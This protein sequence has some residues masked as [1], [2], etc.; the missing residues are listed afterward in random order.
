MK[1]FDLTLKRAKIEKKK[2][3]D[4]IATTPF[5]ISAY[6]DF[7]R[8]CADLRI[9]PTI[10]LFKEYMATKLKG[11][12]VGI[13]ISAREALQYRDSIKEGT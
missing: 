9:D 6:D 5:S 8:A 12:S 11:A 7:I 2:Y 3:M 4:V 1:T 10:K 13:V